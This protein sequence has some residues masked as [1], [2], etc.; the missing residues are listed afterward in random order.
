[1]CVFDF[2][3]PP[4]FCFSTVGATSIKNSHSSR[5]YFL[6]GLNKRAPIFSIPIPHGS[7]WEPIVQCLDLIVLLLFVAVSI[8]FDFIYFVRTI[9][10]VRRHLYNYAHTT[11]KISICSDPWNHQPS[12]P[13]THDSMAFKTAQVQSRKEQNKWNALTICAGLLLLQ[14]NEK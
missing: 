12:I 6:F 4:F 3:G 1:M 11:P 9:V 7:L 5:C 13:L 10:F 8:L 2:P 14:L